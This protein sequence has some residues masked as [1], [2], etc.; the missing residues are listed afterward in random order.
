MLAKLTEGR[1]N[2]PRS[3]SKRSNTATGRRTTLKHRGEDCRFE[4]ARPP[5]RSRGIQPMAGCVTC[6]APGAGNDGASSRG[7]RSD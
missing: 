6:G 7:S 2:S 3:S 1:T 5:C 4:G